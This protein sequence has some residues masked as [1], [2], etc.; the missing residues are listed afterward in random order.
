ML[1]VDLRFVRYGTGVGVGNIELVLVYQEQGS[2]IVHW[3]Y[4][5]PD[6]ENGTSDMATYCA[7]T[8][9]VSKA[10]LKSKAYD[11]AYHRDVSALRMA[12]DSKKPNALND[13]VRS[14]CTAHCTCKS[15]VHSVIIQ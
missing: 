2:D 14:T 3:I 8:V 10:T 6:K 1:T 5:Q 13:V 9:E 4:P 11:A 7:S 15:R 12:V